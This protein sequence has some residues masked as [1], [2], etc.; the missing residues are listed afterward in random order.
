M[1]ADEITIETA[2]TGKVTVEITVMSIFCE[3][4]CKSRSANPGTKKLSCQKAESAN[5][6][7]ENSHIPRN[8]SQKTRKGWHQRNYHLNRIN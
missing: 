7:E 2:K 8:L 4:K 5:F 6:P 3:K 1:R